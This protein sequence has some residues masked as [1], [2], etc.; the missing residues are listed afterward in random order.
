MLSTPLHRYSSGR[1]ISRAREAFFSG[2]T[3]L[4]L[5]TERFHFYRRYKIRGAH[6]VVFYAPPD[7]AAFYAEVSR[8]ALDSQDG[9][10]GEGEAH[11]QVQ[12]SRFDLLSLQR[13]LGAQAERMVQSGERA[14][15]RF[16]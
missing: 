6:S 5:I 13:I 2:R 7:H 16:A 1:D 8:F 11:V 15:W 9:G 12:Y 10:E 3:R 4:L 14:V